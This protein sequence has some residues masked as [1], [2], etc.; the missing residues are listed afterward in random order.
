[1]KP[2]YL[3]NHNHDKGENKIKKKEKEKNRKEIVTLSPEG[4]VYFFFSDLFW[5]FS[6][7]KK[8]YLTFSADPCYHYQ[9]L[10]DASRKSSYKTLPYQEMCDDQ[11]PEVWYRFVGAAGTKMP[12]G[13]V[14]AY[15]CG[16]V[17]SGWLMT[18]HP[19]VEDGEVLR[20]VC[21]SDRFT[22][23]KY[24]SKTSVKNC[25]SYFIYKFQRPPSCTSRY[26]GTDWMW[27]KYTWRSK[28][29]HKSNRRWRSWP[30]FSVVKIISRF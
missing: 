28:R 29:I 17:W 13:R 23:C 30:F 6:G 11:L 9:S 1:M 16:T 12:T 27:N 22:S 21:F 7:T 15:R 5:P 14:P 2:N 18:A 25:G 20:T 10:S 19:T 4:I 24:S 26:C 8:E 3:T